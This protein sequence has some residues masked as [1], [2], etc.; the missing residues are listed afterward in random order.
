MTSLPEAITWIDRFSSGHADG[1]LTDSLAEST[2]FAAKVRSSSLFVN[3]SNRFDRYGA[4]ATD[5]SPTVALGMT[6]L[7]SRGAAARHPGSIDLYA[8]TTIK[9]IVS[10]TPP[11]S[12]G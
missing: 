11:H 1:I 5:G 9:R 12:P 2:L 3:A 7:K 10:G 6:G 4:A 8:L